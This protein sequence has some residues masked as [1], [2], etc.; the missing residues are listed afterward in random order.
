LPSHPEEEPFQPDSGTYED[1]ARLSDEL[2]ACADASWPIGEFERRACELVLMRTVARRIVLQFFDEIKPEL[3]SVGQSEEE[4]EQ[5]AIDL[6][7]D[8]RVISRLFLSPPST[9]FSAPE[10]TLLVVAGRILMRLAYGRRRQWALGERVKELSCLYGMANLSGQDCLPLPE[11]LAGYAA[12]I[13]PAWQH[14]A[15]TVGRITVE[16]ETAATG[17]MPPVCQKQSAVIGWGGEERGRIEVAY[18]VHKPEMDEG[19]FLKD[20]RHLLDA[21]AAHISLVLERRAATGE[22]QRLEEQLRHADRLATIGQL[23]AGV[24]HELNEPLGAIIG[25]AQ[26]A[27]KSEELPEQP[28]RDI[29]KILAAALHAREVVRKLML[30]AR[31]SPPR[32]SP[33]LLNEVIEEGLYFLEAQCLRHGIVLRRELDPDL[34][35]LEADR[36]QLRQV[37]VNLVVNAIQAMPGGG[38][39]VIRT[40]SDGEG[41]TLEVTDTG[42][43]MPEEV[44]QRILLPF[45]TTKDVGQGTGLGLAVV[46]GIVDAHGGRIQVES[47]PGSGSRFEIRLPIGIGE[48]GEDP[49]VRDE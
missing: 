16:G 20:E 49:H 7:R 44:R 29:D 27:G 18:V 39:L 24:A 38:D 15:D 4:A 48:V 6:E 9:G 25:F 35:P 37:L 40:R 46:H 12:L 2:V 3:L 41:V 11:L 10:R 30:F 43:G 34:R 47:V 36:G 45:F 23:A 26:L 21:I 33:V 17:E 19:P 22:Q 14:P 8:G 13:P 32:K 42:C 28:A 1:L 5:I 31:P